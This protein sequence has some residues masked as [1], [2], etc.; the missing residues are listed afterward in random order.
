MGDLVPVFAEKCMPGDRWRLGCENLIRLAPMLAPMM[1]RVDVRVEYFF[2]PNRLLW[3]NWETWS[4]NGGDD[5]DPVDPLP[6]HP[7]TGFSNAVSGPSAVQ[8]NKL[9]DYMGLPRPD[10][11][12]SPLHVEVTD[13]MPFAAYQKIYDDYYRDE[14]LIDKEVTSYTC[15]DG[16]NAA[17]AGMFT[18]RKRAWEADYLTKALPFAQK[19]EPVTLPLIGLA[20]VPVRVN[21]A[22]PPAGTGIIAN[23]GTGPNPLLISGDVPTYGADPGEDLYAE[24]SQ[25]VA[26]QTTVNDYR[27]A[28]KLQEWLELNA[29]GGTRY[30]ELIRAHYN[31]RPED[32]RLQRAEYIVGVKNPIQISE[33][34]QTSETDAGSPQGNMAGHGVSYSSGNYGKYFCTEFGWIIGIL[35][36]MPRTGYQQGIP[37]QFLEIGD[38]TELPWPKFA[39]LGER[40]IQNKEVMA[41][42]GAAGEDT[43]GY[44]PR[45][46]E[47]KQRQNRVAGDFRTTLDF[48]HMGRI[49]DT[50]SP[51]A[52]NAAFINSDPTKRVFAVEDGPDVCWCSLMHH[53]TAI[54]PLP[55]Y[56]TPSLF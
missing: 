1:H 15:I 38:P 43:F 5:V 31:V 50:G 41:F 13:C 19:G 47:Y 53:V 25:L 45:Y 17:R 9:L 33:V 7:F 10:Q 27:T 21:N 56:G 12:P 48:W 29:R 34:L 23:A 55:F 30:A 37:K 22:N 54:R 49:F 44:T 35:S 11:G 6:A 24:T 46:I 26:Q 40:P 42:R 14:N 51:P 3:D 20:D 36:V 32:A 28:I 4:S 18:L 8:Y 39:N 2:V 16:N 52:L